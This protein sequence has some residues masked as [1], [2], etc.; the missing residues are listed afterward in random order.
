MSIAKDKI[1]FLMKHGATKDEAVALVINELE[2][3][4][5][6]LNK[7]VGEQRAKLDYWNEIPSLVADIMVGEKL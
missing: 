2:F 1:K 4:T 7:L 6:R 3:E 5:A